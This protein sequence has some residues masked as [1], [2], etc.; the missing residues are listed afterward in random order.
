MQPAPA[1]PSVNRTTNVTVVQTAPPLFGGY[2][3][4]MGMGGYGMASPMGGFGFFPVRSRSFV[5][6]GI[7]VVWKRFYTV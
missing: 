4:G 2:G 5:L 1:S 3:Y 6:P 7:R